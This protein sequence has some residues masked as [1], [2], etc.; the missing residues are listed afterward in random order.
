[1]RATCLTQLIDQPFENN[2]GISN[3][4][5]LFVYGKVGMTGVSAGTVG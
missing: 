5:E 1:M 2:N 3:V 4:T